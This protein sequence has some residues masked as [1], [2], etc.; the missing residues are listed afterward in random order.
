[1]EGGYQDEAA[2]FSVD[3]VETIVRHAIHNVLQEAQ[4]NPKKVN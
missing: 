2:D 1:M 4:F 3:D